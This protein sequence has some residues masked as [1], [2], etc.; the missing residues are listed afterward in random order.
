MAESKAAIEKRFIEDKAVRCS[1]MN[2]HNLKLLDRQFPVGVFDGIPTKASAIFT[3][4][5]SAI[6]LVGIGHDSSF[7]LFELKAEKNIKVGALSELFF[8][9]MVVRDVLLRRFGFDD[10]K[11]D[12]RATI[13]P[14]HVQAAKQTGSECSELEDRLRRRRSQQFWTN[15]RCNCRTGA[16]GASLT[17][18]CRLGRWNASYLVITEGAVFEPNT[19]IG[20][21][22]H[23]WPVLHPLARSH[24]RRISMRCCG[25]DSCPCKP[26]A[27]WSPCDIR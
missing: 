17:L 16:E 6:D 20:Q 11:P 7:W 19:T 4:G 22:S 26:C 2:A 1:F 24:R 15:D 25:V 10:R 5:K 23:H 14:E 18:Q 8:Y 9:S 3:G 27:A 12:S 21:G 13:F